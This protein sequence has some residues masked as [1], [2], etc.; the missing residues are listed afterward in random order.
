MCGGDGFIRLDLPLHH[1]EYGKAVRCTA[2]V[3]W[4]RH[5]GLACHERALTWS[6]L[7]TNLPTDPRGYVQALEYAGKRMLEE[8]FGFAC[9]Y[10]NNGTGKSRW[11]KIMVAEA[12]R[13][14]LFTRYVHGKRLEERLFTENEDE[15][16]DGQRYLDTARLNHYLSPTVL[17]IDEAQTI[18]WSNAWVAGHIG[19]LL[20][21]R[22]DMADA[23][24]PQRKVTILIG[25]FHPRLWA[26]AQTTAFLTSRVSD[27]SFGIPWHE[28]LAGGKPAPKA[29][30]Q[31]PCPACGVKHK[32]VV[33]DGRKRRVEY[34]PQMKLKKKLLVCEECGNS[35]PL[36]VWWPFELPMVDV[37]PILPP[38]IDTINGDFDDSN[39]A[40][41][42]ASI[43]L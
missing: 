12:C 36:E 6:D 42:I 15:R 35:R 5:S 18:N 40:Q 39:I 41:Q 28:E 4:Y 10:G 37:R 29:L 14:H 1:P 22:H 7:Y 19:N 8:R 20:S 11:A 33:S 27:G 2:C 31:R 16:D 30:H 24:K 25:Q 17:V 43:P 3:D 23:D 38:A 9:V 13:L 34:E 26:S 32:E 21:A